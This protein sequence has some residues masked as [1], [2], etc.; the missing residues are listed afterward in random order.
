VALVALLTE[1]IEPYRATP[2]SR[3]SGPALPMRL[4]SS[5]DLPFHPRSSGRIKASS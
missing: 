5:A 4:P 3:D 1:P 2:K